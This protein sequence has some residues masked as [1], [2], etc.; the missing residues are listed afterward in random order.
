MVPFVVD[1]DSTDETRRVLIDRGI[2]HARFS[3]QLGVSAGWNYGLDWFFRQ[4]EVEQVLVVGNDTFLP[5]NFYR[6][7]SGVRGAVRYG[8]P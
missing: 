4:P 5:S 1:N 2:P 3:P 6:E 8:H 7:I